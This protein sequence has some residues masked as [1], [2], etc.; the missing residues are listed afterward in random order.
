MN[1]EISYLVLIGCFS[2]VL[3]GGASSSHAGL[4]EFF[5]P[6]MR[7]N[8]EDPVKTLEAPFAKEEPKIQSENIQNAPDYT[9][10]SD[11]EAAGTQAVELNIEQDTGN[12]GDNVALNLPHRT[13]K[14]IGVWAV[15]AVSDTMTYT[16]GI[17][18][19]VLKDN[20]KI[21]N[22][23]G[24]KQYLDF[25]SKYKI[26][27]VAQSNAY[28]VR[29]YVNSEPLLLNSGEVDGR[30]RWLFQ[31]SVMVSYMQSGVSSYKDV[32]PINNLYKMRVQIGRNPNAADDLG[33]EIERWSGE[34]QDIKPIDV[35]DASPF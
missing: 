24:S 4:L 1:R 13:N 9:A 29:A 16:G 30:Y 3:M 14:D 33:V 18:K 28:D 6:G 19:S 2:T 12:G 23:T 32:E 34:L 35:E 22:S 20:L 11:E 31:V 26:L 15:T 27:S 17:D 21:F 8:N 5:F 25:M 10:L 7:A